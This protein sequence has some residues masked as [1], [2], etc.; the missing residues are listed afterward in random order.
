MSEQSLFRR[1]APYKSDQQH[2][3]KDERMARLFCATNG[4]VSVTRL[5]TFAFR[6]IG[7]YMSE[8]SL[9]RRS[10]PYKS[11]QQRQEKDKRT[12]YNQQGVL[13]VIESTILQ[14]DVF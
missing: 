11:D 5:R 7:V 4:T 1:S 12:S 10:A 6:K 8:Q 3:E 14:S 13:N 2:H 9:F